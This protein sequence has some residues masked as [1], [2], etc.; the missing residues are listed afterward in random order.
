MTHTMVR[1]FVSIGSNVEPERHVAIALD[2]LRQRFGAI[3]VSP[4]YRTAA[5]GFDGDDFLNLVVGFDTAQSVREVDRALDD[6]ESRAG[7][8][9]DAPR[10]APRTL[11]LDLLLFGDMVTEADG[12][13]L[14]RRE[15]LKYAFMLRPL[16]DIA[17][18]CRHPVLGRTMAEL[19]QAQDFSG[20]RCD[21]AD[22]EADSS[23][24]FSIPQ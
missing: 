18:D 5:V 15:L 19:L 6:I 22:F 23:N 10:F 21:R 24:G 1:A 8:D 14:P 17:P 16:A 2:A 20:Q 13:R 9:R 11:D 12:L 3:E 7:R 4:V